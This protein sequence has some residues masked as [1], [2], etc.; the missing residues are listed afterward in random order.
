MKNGLKTSSRKL[1]FTR[2][3][4]WVSAGVPDLLICDEKGLF[5]FVELK[6]ITA[7]AVNIRPSQ[8][9][10]LTRHE[11]SSSWIL[12]KRVQKLQSLDQ[13]PL[14]ELFLYQAKQVLELVEQGVKLSPYYYQK[15][16]SF[17]FDEIYRLISPIYYDNLP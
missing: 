2:I 15:S 7:N 8:I 3:E 4:S 5:H 1:K 17:K 16:K 14:P 9:S 11:S 12:V 13:N 10:W 6:F